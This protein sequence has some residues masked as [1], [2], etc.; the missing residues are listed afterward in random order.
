MSRK[1]GGGLTGAL[2]QGAAGVCVAEQRQAQQAAVGLAGV[3][4]AVERGVVEEQLPVE[5][6]QLGTLV[7]AVRVRWLWGDKPVKTHS[8]TLKHN[9]AHDNTNTCSSFPYGKIRM[10][11]LPEFFV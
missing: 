11:Q 10:K 5:A 8:N 2:P 9:Q 4:A 7:Q 6:D 3:V 1:A